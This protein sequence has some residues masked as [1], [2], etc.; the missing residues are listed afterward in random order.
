[1]SL[2][3]LETIENVHRLPDGKYQGD[4]QRRTIII[5][6]ELKPVLLEVTRTAHNHAPVIVIVDAGLIDI[7]LGVENENTK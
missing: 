4:W 1:M 5:Y 2:R 7:Y 3:Y 6:V